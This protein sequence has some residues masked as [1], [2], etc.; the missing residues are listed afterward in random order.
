MGWV[1]AGRKFAGYA[2]V[3]DEGCTSLDA[4]QAEGAS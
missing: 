2:D 4:V 1:P 3:W